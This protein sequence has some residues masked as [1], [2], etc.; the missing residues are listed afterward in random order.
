M[1]KIIFGILIISLFINAC[2]K[3]SSTNEPTN[4]AN[5]CKSITSFT[6]V[7][8]SGSL[9]FNIVSD[10][11]PLY[12]EVSYQQASAT[13][14]ADYGSKFIINGLTA[15]KTITELAISQ[16]ATYVFYIRAIC[17]SESSS[18]WSSPKALTISSYCN[19]P[20][21][22]SYGG[23]YLVWTDNTDDYPMNA[24][25]QYGPAGFTLGTGTTINAGNT[26]NHSGFTF[27]PNTNYEFYVRTFCN[28]S[29]MW[30]P[31]SEPVN[32]QN[33]N[34]PCNLPSNLSHQIE[35][36]NSTYAYVALQ[37]A[38]NGNTNFEYTVVLHGASANS[39][40]IFTAS[41]SGWPVV[42]LNRSYTYDFYMRTVCSNGA[43]TAWTSP[44]LISNL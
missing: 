20:T 21:N 36:L 40:T 33:G 44:Y 18:D 26:E 5:P 13:P 25:I 24:Q 32:Y 29:Q 22:L 8:Q 19:S 6:V 10:S 35:S 27:T 14:V 41:T 7:Q 39:G 15:T 31:W 2:S 43:R 3:D 37:W 34:S 28:D 16:S 42:N 30:S 12:Y 11:S 1:K 17:S 9:V 38:Y 4:T 23:G